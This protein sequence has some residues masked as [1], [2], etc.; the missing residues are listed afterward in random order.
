MAGLLRVSGHPAKFTVTSV[1]GARPLLIDV[2]VDGPSKA[3][4]GRRETDL[5]VEFT[6][7]VSVEGEYSLSV[8]HADRL[9][10]P[11]SPFT[12][13]FTSTFTSFIS[14]HLTSFQMN[15]L[16]NWIDYLAACRIAPLFSSVEFNSYSTAI[17]PAR[18]LY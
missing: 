14:S 15:S 2:N 18:L 11:G 10:I 1:D 4:L 16:N 13:R 5:G 7:I 8:V 17:F 6:F 12:T 9:H 3:R